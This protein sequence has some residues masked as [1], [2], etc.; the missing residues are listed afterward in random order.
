MKSESGQSYAKLSPTDTGLTPERIA[1]TLK[2][3]QR[4]ESPTRVRSSSFPR[5]TVSSCA[6][7]V[8][9]LPT[10]KHAANASMN[11]QSSRFN[12][13]SLPERNV[14]QDSDSNIVTKLPRGRRS[15]F[16]SSEKDDDLM[17]LSTKTQQPRDDTKNRAADSEPPRESNEPYDEEET[18]YR[19]DWSEE[20]A[21][22]RTMKSI[23]A[24]IVQE[25]SDVIVFKGNRAVLRVT[26]QGCPEPTVKW[27]RVVRSTFSRP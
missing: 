25:P 24:T 17:K 6:K 20:N 19:K 9:P 18:C 26:Y 3:R 7:H 22:T 1:S 2:R 13:E 5:R 8:S 16:S 21:E 10:R 15:S 27:L 4:C 11:A 12:S 23:G 14:K